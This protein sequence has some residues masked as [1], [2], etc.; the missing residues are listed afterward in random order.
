[1]TAS[2]PPGKVDRVRGMANIPLSRTGQ[3]E[4]DYLGQ[5]IRE[6]GG[7]DSIISS[8]LDRAKETTAAILRHNPNIKLD[9]VTKD[10]DPLHQGALEG[11]PV[12]EAQAALQHYA[13]N[14]DERFPGVG[15]SGVPGESINEHSRRAASTVHKLLH[16]LKP[17]E[18]KLVSA[19]NSMIRWLHG[20]VKAGGGPDLKSNP[21]EMVSR[22]EKH[23]PAAALYRLVKKNGRAALE[24]NDIQSNEPVK[25]GLNFLRHGSTA[26]HA[27][28]GSSV[29]NRLAVMGKRGLTS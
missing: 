1:M 22:D 13:H 12:H 28:T 20:W 17:G 15:L 25:P 9:G 24:P 6:K 11:R 7:A 16:S 10:L 5:R 14:P 2:P 18:R 19:H 23:E 3:L 4:A 27:E 21:E 29:T 26:F 8:D